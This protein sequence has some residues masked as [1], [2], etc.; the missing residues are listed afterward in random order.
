MIGGSAE[1]VSPKQALPSF[2]VPSGRRLSDPKDPN[3]LRLKSET[4]NHAGKILSTDRKLKITNFKMIE[5][6]MFLFIMCLLNSFFILRYIFQSFFQISL[7]LKRIFVDI[8]K[9]SQTYCQY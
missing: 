7:D 9:V 3:S 4:S 8:I 6:F 2:R 1:I 5:S